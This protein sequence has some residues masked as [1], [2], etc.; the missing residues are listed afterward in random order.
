MENNNIIQFLLFFY[1]GWK[2]E[3]VVDEKNTH[4]SPILSKLAERTLLSF[5]SFSKMQENY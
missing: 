2:N 5:I 1:F 4:K 3:N